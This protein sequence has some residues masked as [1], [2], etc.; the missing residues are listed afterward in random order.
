M[1]LTFTC[2]FPGYLK[3]KIWDEDSGRHSQQKV[4][5]YQNVLN[6]WALL[7]DLVP[8]LQYI[9][10]LR[11]KQ[12]KLSFLIWSTQYK[13]LVKGIEKIQQIP[14][15]YLVLKIIRIYPP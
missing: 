1:I 4:E 12:N 10:F 9:C 14:L 15:K 5:I 11:Q 2:F 13:V 3:D 6:F 8:T 7:K